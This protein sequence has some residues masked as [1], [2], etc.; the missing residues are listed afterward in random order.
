MARTQGDPPAPPS[1]HNGAPLPD[2]VR[3]RMEQ[4]FGAD[5]SDVRVH[6]NSHALEIGAI[7]YTR[8]SAVH[9]APG[10]YAPDDQAGAQLLAHE[11]AHVVQQRSGSPASPA[12]AETPARLSGLPAAAGEPANLVLPPP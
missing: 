7:A 1:F 2:P 3:S 4:S 10:R 12:M 8:G 6:A 9:F 11:L 5:F